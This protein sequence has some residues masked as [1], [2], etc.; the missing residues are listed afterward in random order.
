MQKRTC[1]VNVIYKLMCLLLH[2]QE[3]FPSGLANLVNKLVH[4]NSFGYL[5]CNPPREI[6]PVFLT[7]GGLIY[8]ISTFN[9]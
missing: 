5:M 7:K 2:I 3:I 9:D 1:F 8:E 4:A 6:F